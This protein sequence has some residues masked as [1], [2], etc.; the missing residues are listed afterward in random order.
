[1]RREKHE[2]GP[3]PGGGVSTWTVWDDETGDAQMVEYD[4]A[5]GVIVRHEWRVFATPTPD[6]SVGEMVSFDATGVETRRRR[7]EPG[8]PPGLEI[9]VGKQSH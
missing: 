6:G 7:L 3:T 9:S 5:G 4:Q 1:M 8:P 2:A